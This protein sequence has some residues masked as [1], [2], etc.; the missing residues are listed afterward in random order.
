MHLRARVIEGRDAKEHIV[1]GLGMVILLH[2][3]RVHK[4]SVLMDDRLGEACGSRGEI[5]RRVVIIGQLDMGALGGAIRNQIIVALREG[6]TVLTYVEPG[7]DALYARADLLNT[8]RKFRTEDNEIRVGKLKTVFD[9][10]CGI[11][12]I[13][14]NRQCTRLEDTEVN[15]KP[16]NTVHQKDGDLVT[17]L[18]ASGQEQIGKTVCLFIEITPGDL[19]AIRLV[20]IRL[21][22]RV[23]LPGKAGLLFQLGIDLHK[24]DVVGVKI[25]I[26]L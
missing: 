3:C 23:F 15:G 17:L 7:L 24:T 16:F 18:Y 19:A 2:H 14:R 21:D 20:G 22:Q 9:L 10:V 1:L 8:S 12:V 6:G 5:N 25:R 26:F 13:Q 4:A 11:T